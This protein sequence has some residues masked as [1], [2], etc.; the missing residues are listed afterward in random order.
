MDKN[1][2][3]REGVVDEAVGQAKI[4]QQVRVSFVGHLNKLSD[5]QGLSANVRDR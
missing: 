3:A 2:P 4:R 5:E 1:D